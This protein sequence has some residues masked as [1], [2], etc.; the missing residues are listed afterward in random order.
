MEF[1]FV[2]FL[3]PSLFSDCIEQSGLVQVVPSILLPH[4]CRS[5]DSYISSLKI[6]VWDILCI[7]YGSLPLSW[8]SLNIDLIIVILRKIV[9]CLF[10]GKRI[11]SLTRRDS[12]MCLF[13]SVFCLFF[14]ILFYFPFRFWCKLNIPLLSL[15]ITV[16]E[17]ILELHLLNFY[18]AC[19][20]LYFYCHLRLKS[21]IN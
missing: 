15:Q 10:N 2:W 21:K 8:N 20:V 5:R 17:V 3:V 12:L 16:F 4:I 6:K 19:L 9:C 1:S 11:S 14:G 18:L 7:V 13:K